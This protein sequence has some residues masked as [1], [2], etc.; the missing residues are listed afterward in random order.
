[1]AGVVLFGHRFD[2]SSAVSLQASVVMEPANQRPRLPPP[3]PPTHTHSHARVHTHARTHMHPYAHAHACMCAR[4]HTYK[5]SHVRARMYHTHASSRAH[6]QSLTHTRACARTYTHT[7]TPKPSRVCRVAVEEQHYLV[8][9]VG[10]SIWLSW[11]EEDAE[12]ALADHPLEQVFFM[13]TV[14]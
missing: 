12:L 5:H 10:E 2:S 11:K 14:L 7:H 8:L 6:T 1:M 13:G 4:T 3:H 9:L